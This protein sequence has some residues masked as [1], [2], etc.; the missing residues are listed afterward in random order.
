MTFSHQ[1]YYLYFQLDFKKFG[2]LLR[3][4]KIKEEIE[5]ISSE[6]DEKLHPI[7]KQIVIDSLKSC[8][9]LYEVCDQI[10]TS[11]NEKFGSGWNCF[12]FKKSLGACANWHFKGKY[13]NLSISNFNFV[14]F[15]QRLF[16]YFP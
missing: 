8:K 1:N 10:R 12:I 5:I 4:K 3:S 14:M 16:K 11:F 6:M 2:Q 9:D 7:I 13:I 15:S